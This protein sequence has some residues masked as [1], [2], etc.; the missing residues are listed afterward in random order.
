MSCR[1]PSID[2]S[3][4]VFE[5]TRANGEHDLASAAS[6]CRLDRKGKV[7][8]FAVNSSGRYRGSPDC[9]RSYNRT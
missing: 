1:M 5:R 8:V 2:L 9:P 7:T 4:K 6:N 3:N